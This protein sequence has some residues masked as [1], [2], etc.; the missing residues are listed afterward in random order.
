MLYKRAPECGKSDDQ[1]SQKQTA[2]MYKKLAMGEVLNEEIMFYER[3]PECGNSTN[4]MNRSLRS[5]PQQCAGN[6][7]GELKLF[8]LFSIQAKWTKRI[9]IIIGIILKKIRWNII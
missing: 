2:T 1:E 7:I 4:M 5:K 6:G 9:R 8:I 3:A